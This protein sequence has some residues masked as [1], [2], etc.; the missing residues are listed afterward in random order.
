[1]NL[2]TEVVCDPIGQVAQ[3]AKE[4]FYTIVSD[5]ERLKSAKDCVQQSMTNHLETGYGSEFCQFGST[6]ISY[7]L[8]MMT[9]TV[10][11]IAKRTRPQTADPAITPVSEPTSEPL[12]RKLKKRQQECAKIIE[13]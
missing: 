5:E 10:T 4:K 2:F 1:M 11:M 9:N 6:F 7:L 13:Q 8:Q 3:I 12:A